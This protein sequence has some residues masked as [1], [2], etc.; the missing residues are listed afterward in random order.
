MIY[1]TKNCWF[2]NE[3]SRV[4]I[5]NS[6][7]W[8]CQKC[9]QYNGFTKDG[10][11][12]K[13]IPEMFNKNEETT[14]RIRRGKNYKKSIINNNR[15]CLC[16]NCNRNQEIKLNKLSNYESKNEDTYDFEIE[17]YKDYLDKLYDLCDNC[18]S[19][20]KFEIRKQDGI[21]KQYLFKIG[22]FEYFFENNNKKKCKSVDR[23]EEFIRNTGE[24]RN[25]LN[26]I[27]FLIISY[28]LIHDYFNFNLFYLNLSFYIIS[29]T[30]SFFILLFKNFNIRNILLSILITV[31]MYNHYLN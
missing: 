30:I 22:S 20:V 3:L 18:K 5:F 16:E 19:K 15:N 4:S 12:N 27:I 29:Y 24:E 11:Y 8:N 25:F 28:L 14:T 13:E 6:N 7:S 31:S 23:K 1:L 10:D 26:S 2:C 17:M 21:L 9:S